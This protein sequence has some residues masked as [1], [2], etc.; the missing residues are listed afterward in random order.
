[1]ARRLLAW[2][3][4]TPVA[5]AGIFLAHAFAYRLSGT[6][7]GPLHEYLAHGPQVVGVLATIA[8]VGLACQQRT[9]ATRSGW[10]IS[11]TDP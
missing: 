1:M 2:T 6:D 4:V 3:L 11:S 7:P 8:I 9:I 5:A 10:I